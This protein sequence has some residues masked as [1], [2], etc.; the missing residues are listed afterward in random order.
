MSDV[1][2]SGVFTHT[3]KERKAM[4][5]HSEFFRHV[6]IMNKL[7][8]SHIPYTKYGFIHSYLDVVRPH[9]GPALMTLRKPVCGG[10]HLQAFF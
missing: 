9:I 1:T 6:L 4:K 7:I 5:G 3:L 10:G 2:S 8:E